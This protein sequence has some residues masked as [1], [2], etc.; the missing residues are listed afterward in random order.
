MKRRG[1]L[2]IWLA[3]AVLAITACE[4]PTGKTAEASLDPATYADKAQDAALLHESVD[5]LTEVIIH[6]IFSPPVAARI[7]AYP[8]IAAYEILQQRD[9]E[10]R[11]L[12][13]QLTD[14]TAIP[15]P[16]AG[17]DICYELSALHAFGV[18]GRALIFSEAK[19]TAHLESVHTRY[20]EMG[21]R[22][23]RFE[24][25]VAYG[26]AV[27]QHILAWSAS[28]R[29]KQT[30]TFAKY[31]IDRDQPSRWQPTPPKYHEGIE[32][33]WREIRTFVL[34]SAQQFMPPRP[35]A[36][37]LDKSSPFYKEVM[38]VYEAGKLERGDLSPEREEQLAIA[39]FWD[40]NPYVVS[41]EGHAMYATKKITPG[42]HWMGITRI[43]CETAEA[44]LLRTA[45]AYAM[46]T[47]A[48]MDGF[49]S[50]WDEK[51]RSNLVRPET[52]INTYIDENWMPVLQTPPFPEYTSGHSVVSGAAST[53]LTE[54]FGEDFAF[55]DTSEEPYGLPARNFSSFKAAAEEAAISRLYG[56][57]HYMPAIENGIVQGRAIGSFILK[58]V[59]T[60]IPKPM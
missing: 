54:L 38:E 35:T 4:I 28:D 60:R 41:I 25:S 15:T 30:R 39:S 53:V 12:A 16:D 37:S 31:S 44:D 22:G 5:A 46:T 20:R 6:D 18:V 9:E 14:L 26:E 40:C 33:H 59:E 42:G 7:Y 2:W 13:G 19:M 47:L 1:T 51:Y 55:R 36:F 50:C 11:S 32:P 43:A 3:A 49:I 27:A 21:V 45:E 17:Q 23:E 29:Y 57:I 52:Y 8:S 56:G 24:Q 58:E 10:H 48:L 34:D